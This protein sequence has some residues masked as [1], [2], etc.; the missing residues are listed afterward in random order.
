MPTINAPSVPLEFGRSTMAD[1]GLRLVSSADTT[2][3]DDAASQ[4]NALDGSWFRRERERIAVSRRTVASLLHARERQIATVE[5]RRLPVPETWLAAVEA[6]GFR[7]P[8]V[9]VESSAAT[10]VPD[11]VRP[12]GNHSSQQLA[13]QQSS[14]S[15]SGVAETTSTSAH[16]PMAASLSATENAHTTSSALPVDAKTADAA[17]PVQI[18]QEPAK[19]PSSFRSATPSEAPPAP[20]LMRGYWMRTRRL[21]LNLSLETI[22]IA[23]QTP[24]P[25]LSIVE[26]HNLIVPPSW[27]PVLGTFHFYDPPLQTRATPQQRQPYLHG[28]WLRRQRDKLGYSNV[29]LS[30]QLWVHPRVLGRVE[31]R[32]WPLPPEWLPILAFIGFPVPEGLLSAEVSPSQSTSLHRRGLAGA[33]LR[34][35]REQKEMTQRVLSGH[36]KVDEEVVRRYEDNN[37]PLPQKWLVKLL[38]LGFPLPKGPPA[39]SETSTPH[40]TPVNPQAPSARPARKTVFPGQWLRKQREQLKLTQADVAH[41][42]GVHQTVVSMIE[43]EAPVIPASWIPKLKTLG[44]VFINGEPAQPP[45]ETLDGAWLKRHR[46]RLKRSFAYLS[47]TLHVNRWALQEAERSNTALPLGWLPGLKMLGFPVSETTPPSSA[48][49]ENEPPVSTPASQR[50]QLSGAWLR[51]HRERM[52]LRQKALSEELGIPRSTL[53]QV[54]LK[55]RSINPQWLGVLKKMGFPIPAQAALPAMAPTTTLEPPAPSLPD[56]AWLRAE[57]ERLGLSRSTLAS[58]LHK[59]EAT[60]RPVENGSSLLPKG[61]LP[62][63]QQLGFRLPP[64]APPEERANPSNSPRKPDES[65]PPV[66][67]QA[68]AELQPTDRLASPPPTR[69][70]ELRAIVETVVSYRLKL[71]RFSGQSAAELLISIG[72]DLQQT[73]LEQAITFEQIEAALRRLFPQ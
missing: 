46:L 72:N 9:A 32:D 52:G 70:A 37:W 24:Q 73:G 22:A 59:M 14:I 6:L 5:V 45:P 30:E 31:L 53:C 34:Q 25:D 63:L 58:R 13:E 64:T 29:D 18:E 71:G 54:E 39:E 47:D 27:V 50:H 51:R 16:V 38:G 60:L 42:L 7:V 12:G 8:R 67:K 43:R 49:A 1:M 11:L 15:E 55:D 2:V 21:A 35:H 20:E 26:T 3:L 48:P 36:L 66:P 68:P 56:G 19:S 17:V 57:R 4:P 23:L 10:E 61:W 28:V 44:F 62:I 40:A 69:A 65:I 33:W 41:R